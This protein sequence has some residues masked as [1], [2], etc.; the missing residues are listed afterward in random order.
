MSADSDLIVHRTDAARVRVNLALGNLQDLAFLHR[1][2]T[3]RPLHRAPWIDDAAIQND[4]DLLP[5]E[6]N[7]AGDFLC[8]PFGA[9]DVVEGP[10]HGWSANSRWAVTS[11]TPNGLAMRLER[12]VMGATL[13]KRIWLDPEAPV[14]VQEHR[15]IGGEGALPVAHHPMVHVADGG[16]LSFSPKRLALAPDIPLEPGRQVL[17][18]GTHSTDLTAFPGVHGAVD[19]TRLPIGTGHEDFVTLVEEDVSSGTLAWT[20]LVREA[21]DDMVF[22]LKDPRVLPVTM[23]WFSNGGRD[24]A[25]WN[26]RHLGVIGIEDGCA[27]G[28]AGHRAALAENPVGRAGV[29]TALTLE[30]QRT[31]HIRH[32]IGAVPR[33]KGWDRVQDIRGE[34]AKLLLTG[35]SGDQMTLPFDAQQ[36][37]GTAARRGAG[38]AEP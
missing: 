1:E 20:A 27:A 36:V 18:P 21:E 25:P 9:S 32:A 14:L 4:P 35:P 17:R 19:L 13:E 10:A 30:P 31:H 24:Y 16:R 7:L 26:G 22:I 2:R 23:L 34:G 3:L 11:D 38:R 28:A 6:R 29:P 37:L 12:K 15:L 5:I 33:P 8:A